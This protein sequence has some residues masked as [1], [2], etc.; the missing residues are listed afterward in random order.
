MRTAALLLALSRVT[1]A[2]LGGIFPVPG[3]GGNASGS[4]PSGSF[5]HYYAITLGTITGT[6]TNFPLCVNTASGSFTPGCITSSNLA[7][8]LNSSIQNT[9]TQTVGPYSVTEPADAVWTVTAPG[10]SA[11]A[12]TCPSGSY[13]PWETESYSAG[14]WLVWMNI[15]SASTGTVVYVCFGQSAMTTQQNSGS[16]SPANVWPTQY[17]TVMHTPNGSTLTL[18]DSTGNANG[19]NNGSSPAIA[20]QL[21]GGVSFASASS[22]YVSFASKVTSGTRVTLSVWGKTSSAANYQMLMDQR[23]SGTS[24]GCFLSFVASTGVGTFSCQGFDTA[25]SST[26][27]ADGNWHYLVGTLDTSAA[28]WLYVDGVQFAQGPSP[29]SFAGFTTTNIQ[30]G[31]TWDASPTLCNCSVDEA[32][33]SNTPSSAAWIA[34]E[35]ANQKPSSSFLTA[36]SLQ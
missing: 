36:G 15:P 26:N 23:G 29:G 16:F 18:A 17:V 28:L 14:S 33:V 12:W 35:Y 10:G 9:V 21:D 1:C 32:R 4:P 25:S 2:Q 7:S 8:N 27:I 24:H 19:T 11:G 13:I 22:Q 31:K 3:P 6:L 5:T 34:A 30:M 20:A